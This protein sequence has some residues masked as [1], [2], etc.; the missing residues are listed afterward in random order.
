MFPLDSLGIVKVLALLP[1]ELLLH[2]DQVLSKAGCK[3][4]QAFA[5]VRNF[6]RLSKS[7]A[8]A[9]IYLPSRLNLWKGKGSPVVSEAIL[10]RSF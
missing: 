7:G 4:C 10:I 6:F 3:I 5:Q 8:E 2:I 9:A 1:L